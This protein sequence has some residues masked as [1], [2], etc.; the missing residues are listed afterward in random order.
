MSRR[1]CAYLSLRPDRVA[2]GSFKLQRAVSTCML[3]EDTSA[4]G[5]AHLLQFAFIVVSQISLYVGAGRGD[6]NLFSRSEKTIETGPIIRQDGGA[7]GS[8][9]EQS[10]RW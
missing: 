9:L 10:H 7:T 1:D 5:C 6:Q 3:R 2:D 4:R 8:G